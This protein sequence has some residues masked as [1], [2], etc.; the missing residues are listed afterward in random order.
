M[1]DLTGELLAA[2]VTAPQ[3]RKESALRTLRGEVSATQPPPTGPLLLQ[4]GAAAKLLGVSRSTMYRLMLSGTVEPV[5]IR[6]GT[7][8]IRRADVEA[9]ARDGMADGEAGAQ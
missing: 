7:F 1:T 4:I 8:R 9:L 3:D 5:E 2:M 6:R